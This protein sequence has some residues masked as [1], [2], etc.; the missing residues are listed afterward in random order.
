MAVFG[1]DVVEQRRKTTGGMRPDHVWPFFPGVHGD[2]NGQ[3]ASKVAKRRK[4]R[5]KH[6]IIDIIEN[7][8]S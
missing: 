4:I 3:R 5:P 6:D 7:K 1:L 2:S 8:K